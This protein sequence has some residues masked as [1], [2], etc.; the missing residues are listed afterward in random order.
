MK[1]G[2]DL[3]GVVSDYQTYFL[4]SFNERFGTNY[5]LQDWKDYSFI[6][7]GFT[8]EAFWKMIEEH[9]KIGAW[10]YLSPIEGAI[11]GITTLSQHNSIHL[12][13][14]KLEEAK[15]D[16]ITW[17]SEHKIPYD[18][19]SFTLDKSRMAYI[20]GID[21]M[22]EDSYKNA[23]EVASTGIETLLFDRPWNRE[24]TTTPLIQR[25]QNW[26]EIVDICQ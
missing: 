4:E 26:K 6:P 9:A 21:I 24:E 20:L 16:T 11:E 10:R 25:V 8:K 1:L 19:I 18:S 23:V 22:I 5:I 7:E 14:H 15:A 2:I 3:D 17:L 12:I 13:S